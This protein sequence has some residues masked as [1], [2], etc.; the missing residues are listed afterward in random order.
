MTLEPTVEVARGAV[1]DLLQRTAHRPGPARPRSGPRRRLARGRRGF[2]DDVR[3]DRLGISVARVA[4]KRRAPAAGDRRPHRRDRR[5]SS[6]TS[7]TRGS[8]TSSAI[9]GWDPQILVGQRVAVAHA[10]RRRR[11]ASSGASRCTCS[12]TTSARRPSSSM[13]LHVDVGAA[14]ATRRG[15]MVRDRRPGRD[16]CGAPRAAG[17]RLVSRALD[18]RLGCVRRAR[19]GAALAE[20]GGGAGAVAGVAAVQEEIGLRTARAPRRF[21]A[22]A[23]PGR[24]RRRHP[25]HRRP[26]V[27]A[28][29]ARRAPAR[30][31]AR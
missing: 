7:T 31:R 2:A 22:R 15:R 9:G 24:R 3:L 30:L 20:A 8:C 5:C 11:R 17:G 16:R 10:R 27:D 6:P 14:T 26:G 25:R 13:E 1:P 19:G 28:Q 12:R 4:G 29:R 18:N 21:G 23:G